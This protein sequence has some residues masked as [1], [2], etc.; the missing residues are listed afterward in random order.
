MA[1]WDLTNFKERPLAP[2]SCD[3]FHA[4]GV[5]S[6]DAHDGLNVLASCSL[7]GVVILRIATTGKLLAHIKT[8]TVFARVEYRPVLVR[9]SSRGYF[10]ML[11]RPKELVSKNTDY[12]LV[13]SIYGE[14]IKAKDSND[15]LN[16]LVFDESGCWFVAG[17]RNG[18]LVRYPLLTLEPIELE[19]AV[20]E[21]HRA[22]ITALALTKQEN[23]QQ[24]FV[25]FSNGYIYTVA[26]VST[27]TDSR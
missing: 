6:L 5:V 13:Y 14:L 24:L 10:V 23:Y 12:L 20:P 2:V 9:L 17:G 7:D 18:Q 16:A 1:A 19:P 25:G 27:S 15:R 4:T 3:N 11:L 26:C 21:A 8:Q 22:A